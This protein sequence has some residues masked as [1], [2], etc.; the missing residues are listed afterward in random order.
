M[1]VGP[2]WMESNASPGFS[3]RRTDATSAVAAPQ[4]VSYTDFDE[5]A[6]GGM[7]RFGPVGLFVLSQRPFTATALS[8]RSTVLQFGAGARWRGMRVGAAFRGSRER[9]E[10]FNEYRNQQDH[11]LEGRQAV[12]DYLEYA[13]GGG[14]R[15]H[16]ATLDV[17]AEVLDEDF[18]LAG[19][20]ITN[21][22][23]LALQ[24]AADAG[25]TL[26]WAARLEVPLGEAEV[27]AS[28][29]RATRE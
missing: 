11:R 9:E 5:F 7:A 16:G 27:A 14:V 26:G 18:Q 19:A 13:F 17:V 2:T 15:I 22:D 20:Y 29:D 21:Q 25:G 24:L 28:A 3:S 23:T 1:R 10:R 8:T 4:V 12:H 6:L